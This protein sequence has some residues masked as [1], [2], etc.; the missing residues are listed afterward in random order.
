MG[1]FTSPSVS[2]T[3]RGSAGG[4][5]DRTV[6]WVRGDH[7]IATRVSLAVGIARAAQR[8]DTPLLVDLSGVTFMDASTIGAIV[9]SRNLL[10]R[11]GQSL[12]LR[13]PSAPARRVVDL[14]GLAHL[15]QL[16]PIRST[17]AAAALASW[18]NVLPVTQPGEGDVNEED[19]QVAAHPAPREAV[20]VLLAANGSADEGVATVSHGGP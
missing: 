20:R 6:L 15:I 9:E 10:R 5:P 19:A 7:D 4:V 8:D 1:R 18:V 11:R 3:R 12:E 13:A 2:I 14:C 16:E 17:G